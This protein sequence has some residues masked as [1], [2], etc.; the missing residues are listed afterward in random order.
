MHRTRRSGRTI[1]RST[2]AALL[3]LAV[4]GAPASAAPAH[5]AGLVTAQASAWSKKKIKKYVRK[6]AKKQAAKHPGP[7]G[8]PGPAGPQG[9]AGPPAPHSVTKFSCKTNVGQTAPG[10]GTIYDSD[11]LRFQ[12]DCSNNGLTL[13][14][15]Q[16]NA[17][18]T[19]FALA[20][21]GA[22][23]M[24]SVTASAI[25]DGF[26]LSPPAGATGK[27]GVVTYTPFGSDVVITVNYSATFAPG[28]PQGDCV[29]VGTI[30]KA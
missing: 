16:T 21:N 24:Q 5:E 8:P 3:V 10:C 25:N 23:Q 7:P 20:S 18:L 26:I 29:F 28:T 19:H 27:S 13:R 6:Q 9:P 30:V 17:V 4:G 15:T 2:T 22:T 11:G 14:T 12:A 1:L